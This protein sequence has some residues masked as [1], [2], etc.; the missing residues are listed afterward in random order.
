[1]KKAPVIS[2]KNLCIGYN[3][4]KKGE[5]RIHEH[6]A[7][8]LFPGEL[9]C[10]LGP[11][12]AGKSTLLR[13][14]AA[15]QPPIEGTLELEG[16]ILSRYSER[17]LSRKIGVV[18]TDKTQTGGLSVYELVSLGRQPHTGFFGRL[19]RHDKEIVEESIEAVG[20]GHK[21]K[22]YMAELSDGERQKVMIAKA[23][24]QECP[25][26][27]LD[28]PTAFLDVVSRIEI[29]SLLHQ[30]AN[31]QKK[32]ILLSTHDMEQALILADKL[33]LL[34]REGGLVCGTTEDIILDGYMD[35]LFS[36]DDIRFDLLHGVY[37]PTVKWS[38]EIFVDTPDET[39]THWT[40]NALNRNHIACTF[41][42]NKRDRLPVVQ[43]VSAHEIIFTEKGKE[44]RFTNFGSFI[45]SIQ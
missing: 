45:E 16:K 10:L 20:I 8:D 7:L 18:L 1:M 12:G 6:I 15:S 32:T 27:L 13:T 39:L 21:K 3:S 25:L 22:N 24:A 2:A 31:R 28:E 34:S 5:K 23:L 41:D 38:R 36:K 4:G 11:N 43:V 30:I 35:S 14:M 26:I 33:W 19:N 40:V 37:Y 29:M 44:S 42:K 9:T 17:E